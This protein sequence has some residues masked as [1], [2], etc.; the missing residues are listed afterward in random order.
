[1]NEKGLQS[2]LLC[3]WYTSDTQIRV[4]GYQVVESDG[5]ELTFR[6]R[7]ILLIFHCMTE[8]HVFES[9]NIVYHPKFIQTFHIT[10]CRISSDVRFRQIHL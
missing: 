6:T 8:S 10:G 7:Q 4:F 2:C 3:N 5:T 1:M 9:E